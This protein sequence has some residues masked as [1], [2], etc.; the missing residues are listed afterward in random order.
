[1]AFLFEVSWNA[2]APVGRA[3]GLPTARSPFRLGGGYRGCEHTPGW[4]RL[5]PSWKRLKEVVGRHDDQASTT[6]LRWCHGGPSFLI[7]IL[8]MLNNR[9]MAADNA[10]L[11]TL[12]ALASGC[13]AN[14]AGA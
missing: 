14:L 1:M 11:D 6:Q 5:A 9:S 2:K 8:F 7:L 10:V 4:K 3:G 13:S 12:A